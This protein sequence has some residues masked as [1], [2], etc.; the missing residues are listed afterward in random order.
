MTDEPARHSFEPQ[1]LDEAA[2]IMRAAQGS[3]CYVCRREPAPKNLTYKHLAVC[4]RCASHAPMREA[5]NDVSETEAA[6]LRVGMDRAG[7]YLASIG[8]FDLRDLS[9]AELDAFS[10][11]MLCG[12]SEAMAEAARAA[13]PF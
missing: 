13:P 3:Y 5:M 4:G 12:Y 8:K 9:D 1:T 2:H 7:E 6:A 11:H 10:A